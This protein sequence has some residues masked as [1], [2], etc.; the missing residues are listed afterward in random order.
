MNCEGAV[1]LMAVI[2]MV[3]ILAIVLLTQISHG[4]CGK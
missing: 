4:S 3:G 1:I 2:M